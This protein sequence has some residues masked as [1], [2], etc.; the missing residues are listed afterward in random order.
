[1][2]KKTLITVC[3]ALFVVIFCGGYIY[4]AGKKAYADNKDIFCREL[5]VTVEDSTS[6]NLISCREIS[7]LVLKASPVIGMHID[8]IDTRMI[9]H[10]L[11]RRGEIATAEAFTTH[12]GRL[13]ISVTQR[14][15]VV[16]LEGRGKSFYSNSEGFIFPVLCRF[17]VPLVTGAIP[18]TEDRSFKGF[19]SK[20]DERRWL[21]GM[22]RLALHISDDPYWKSQVT[23]IDID[24]NGDAVLYT[25]CGD[26][27]IIFGNTE[28]IEDKFTKIKAFYTHILP[29]EEGERY[30]TVNVKYN[31]QIVCR[32]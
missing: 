12:D 30:T 7:D 3:I 24:N 23:Q 2:L 8:S 10:T 11:L 19:C 20:T 14:L 22:I 26:Q 4:F 32:R 28:F 6:N 21:E 25:D 27:R 17:D 18:L 9:E 31:N 13:N 16:R 5:C 1:M 29:T 15:P